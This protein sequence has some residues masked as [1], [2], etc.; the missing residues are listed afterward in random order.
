MVIGASVG[1]R[2]GDF[3]I[4][5]SYTLVGSGV[6]SGAALAAAPF[7]WSSDFWTAS[8]LARIS[9]SP[10]LSSSTSGLH[11]DRT[12]SVTMTGA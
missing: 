10:R 6:G 1:P 3:S 2:I 8:I 4:G 7:A 11:P 9:L 5:M 12:V